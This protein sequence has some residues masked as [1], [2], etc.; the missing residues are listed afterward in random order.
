MKKAL[1]ALFISLIALDSSAQQFSVL[2][3]VIDS[4]TKAPLAGASAFCP[5]TTYGSVSNAEGLFFLKLPAGGYDLVVSYTGYDRKV[6]RI[7]DNQA[8]G[9]T[10]L[11]E[12]PKQDKTMTEV[13]VVASN[14]VADGWNKYGK[15]FTDNF[16]GTS[17]NAA[18]CVLRNPEALKFFYTKKRNRLKVTTKEDLIIDNPSLGYSIRYQLDSFSYDYNNNIS[19]F[20]GYPLFTEIDTTQEVKKKYLINRARTYLGSRLHFMRSMYNSLVSEQGFIVEKLEDNPK[21]VNGTI[22]TDLYNPEDYSNDSGDVV[23]NWTG[24]YRISYKSVF[25]DKKYLEEFKMPSNLRYQITVLDIADGFI[26]ERNGYF[27]EQ[28]DVVN[29]GYWAW[30]KLGEALPYDYVYQ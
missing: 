28:Y 29:N 19:Q 4:A 3:R 25:P 22:I 24:R 20:T 10:L 15:F 1:F 7:S 2:G 17:P 23:I 30:K 21:N 13:A 5:N 6:V 14:E 26:I 11:F 8:A 16:I 18:N 12:L 27:Y 9:D